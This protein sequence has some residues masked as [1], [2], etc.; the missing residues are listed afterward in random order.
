MDLS[1]EVV[2]GENRLRDAVVWARDC[3]R[4]RW[5]TF[6][7]VAAL[8]FVAGTAWVMMMSP[9]YE[10]VAQL[11]LD[12]A[13]D[14]MVDSREREA[15]LSPEAVQTE[16]SMLNSTELGLDVVRPLNLR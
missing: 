4:R 11:R 14:P 1:F 7:A 10:A 3:L 12:P 8:I 9:K 2:K 5:R 6:L 16:V 15:S 13:R